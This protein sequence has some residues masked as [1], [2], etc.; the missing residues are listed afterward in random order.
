LKKGGIPQRHNLPAWQQRYSKERPAKGFDILLAPF[1]IEKIQ[2]PVR[3][4]Q[5]QVDYLVQPF[6]D[7]VLFLSIEQVTGSNIAP[8]DAA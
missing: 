6:L 2:F 1:H 4:W 7:Q 3:R 5:E 8:L